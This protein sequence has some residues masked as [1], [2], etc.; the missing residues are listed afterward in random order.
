MRNDFPYLGC[1]L[2]LAVLLVESLLLYFLV[3][4]FVPFP[5]WVALSVA[6]AVNVGVG[7]YKRRKKKA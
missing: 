3:N 7:L 6:S 2:L 5:W 1:A 4:L